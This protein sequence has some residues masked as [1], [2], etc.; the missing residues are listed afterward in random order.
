MAVR[1]AQAETGKKPRGKGLKPPESGPRAND[2]INLTDEKSR[3]MKVA[4][5]GFEQCF[6]AQAV[7]DTESMRVIATN[8]TQ[9]GNDKEQV[10]PM[11]AKVKAHPEGRRLPNGRPSTMKI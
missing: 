7:V 11:V 1:A 6:N 2:P 3:I 8:V 4:G 9:A 10:E 5:G